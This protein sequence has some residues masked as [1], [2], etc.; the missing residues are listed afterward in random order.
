[1][2]LNLPNSSP[3]GYEKSDQLGEQVI[4]PKRLVYFVK[5]LILLPTQFV[6]C[7]DEYNAR[8]LLNIKRNKLK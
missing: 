5:I 4:T 7:F 6:T 8:L 3:Q 2:E 1:M